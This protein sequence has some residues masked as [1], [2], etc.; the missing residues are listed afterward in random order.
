[1]TLT[2]TLATVQI[3]VGGAVENYLLAQQPVHVPAQVTLYQEIGH[4]GGPF[5]VT[6]MLVTYT[7]L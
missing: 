4:A 6:D 7:A 2:T 3:A 5:D 1:M